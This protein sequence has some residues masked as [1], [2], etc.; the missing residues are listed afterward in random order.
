M[1]GAVVLLE[2]LDGGRDS[3]REE[4]ASLLHVALVAVLQQR[5]VPGRGGVGGGEQM[6]NV[7]ENGGGGGV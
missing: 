3:W 6:S 4:E 1:V 2:L 7:L 5:L